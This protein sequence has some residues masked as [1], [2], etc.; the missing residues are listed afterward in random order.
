[1]ME[2][3]KRPGAGPDGYASLKKHPFFK[4]LDWDNV[5]GMTPPKIV[6]PSTADKEENAEDDDW[7]L[8]G[9]GSTNDETPPKEKETTSSAVAEVN[10]AKFTTLDA[11]DSKWEKFLDPGES[12]LMI[13]LVKKIRKLYNK[14]MQLILTDKPK[15]IYVDPVKMVEKGEI[16]WSN[17]PKELNVQ[18]ADSSYFKICT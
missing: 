7:L 18:V 14:K 3:F 5:R 10:K 15:L 2:P 8:G 9:V 17:D 13:S 11:F 6:P 4:G 1:D 12:I 16:L